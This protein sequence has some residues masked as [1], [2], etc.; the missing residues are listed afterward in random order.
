LSLISTDEGSHGKKQQV[1]DVLFSDTR[2]FS[3]L[4]WAGPAGVA[5]PVVTWPDATG[6]ALDRR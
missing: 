3:T 6:A 5:A 2:N 4:G 1:N